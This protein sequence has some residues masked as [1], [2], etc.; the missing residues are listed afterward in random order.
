M[1][2]TSP[3]FYAQWKWTILM[4][5]IKSALPAACTQ[6]TTPLSLGEMSRL[7]FSASSKIYIRVA[8]QRCNKTGPRQLTLKQRLSELKQKGCYNEPQ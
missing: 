5:F 7:S 4:M 3:N 8:G 2:P 6:A 1:H